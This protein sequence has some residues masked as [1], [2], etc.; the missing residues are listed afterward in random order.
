MPVWHG[1]LLQE[2]YFGDIRYA[3]DIFAMKC[4]I[5]PQADL[6]YI[7]FGNVVENYAAQ[8]KYSAWTDARLV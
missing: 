3:S 2:N 7:A 5:N 6:R 8:S 4:D 1:F